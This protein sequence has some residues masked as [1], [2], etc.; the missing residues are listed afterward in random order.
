MNPVVS[1]EADQLTLHAEAGTHKLVTLSENSEDK[2]S[3][4]DSLKGSH[5]KGAVLRQSLA[6]AIDED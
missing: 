6:K 2:S 3:Q 5:A 4:N 1:L